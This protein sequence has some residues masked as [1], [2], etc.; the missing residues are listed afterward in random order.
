M[1]SIRK[2]LFFQIGLLII[3][4]IC[5]LFFANTVLFEKYYT[6][7]Q[8]EMFIEYYDEINDMESYDSLDSIE[9]FVS[10]ERTS[11]IEIDIRDDKNKMIY[12]T[13]QPMLNRNEH[14]KSEATSENPNSSR[15]GIDEITSEYINNN[16]RYVIAHD[17]VFFNELMILEGQLDNGNLIELK[18]PIL[19]IQKNISIINRFLMIISVVIFI[20]A[21]GFA[22]VLSKYFTL[23]ITEINKVTKRMKNLDFDTVCE[24]LSNDE[25]GQLSENINEMSVELSTAMNSLNSKNDQLLDE[26]SEKN[27][28]DEIRKTLLTNVAHELKTPLALMR[29]YSEA[30]KLNIATS[31]EKSDFYC[32]VISDETSKMNQL[33][34]S[35]LD[36]NQVEFGDK[37]LNIEPFEI[38][39]FITT[40]FNKYIKIIEEKNITYTVNVIKPTM[41][42][43]DPFMMERVFTNYITNAINYVDD[44]L[45]VQITIKELNDIIRIEVYNTC[46]SIS[47]NELDKLWDDFYKVDKART[48]DNG[49]H[50]LGLS[51]VKA[52]QEA[53]NNSYGVKNSEKGIV[54]WFELK[55]LC[56]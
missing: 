21:L 18:L 31:K 25:I 22:Y 32:D 5:L 48:R 3:I 44:N 38:N 20:I 49:G 50:G 39:E 53:H 1:N 12:V 8:K 42:S 29:G 26:I 15:Q 35:L 2:K 56:N 52:I 41:V 46:E 24:V 55:I 43:A 30:L 23:P 7:I 6:A 54:F 33:V 28:L 17:P 45:N 51:I 36:I 11:N 9:K 10:M 16:I 40:H 47:D 13:S 14:I 34:E 19:S 4:L 37:V 27:R